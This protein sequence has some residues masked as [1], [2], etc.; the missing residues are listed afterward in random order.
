MS[1]WRNIKRSKWLHRHTA[2]PNQPNTNQSI[3]S[4]PHSQTKSA[5]PP[6]NPITSPQNI[7]MTTWHNNNN[8]ITTHNTI[9]TWHISTQR[10]LKESDSCETWTHA[11]YPN[12]FRVYRLN[13][14]AKLSHGCFHRVQ[15]TTIQTNQP[16]TNRWTPSNPVSTVIDILLSIAD[17]LFGLLIKCK[18]FCLAVATPG[19]DHSGHNTL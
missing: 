2:K 4:S 19:I 13:R 15:I 8:K 16:T 17:C 9:I 6:N 12:R 1:K 14:S 7:N 11:G 10:R 18:R 5:K 3:T